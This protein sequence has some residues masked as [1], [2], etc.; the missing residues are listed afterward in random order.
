MDNPKAELQNALKEAMRNKDSQRRDTLRLVTS[1]IKQEEVDSRSELDA[2][3]VMK[4]LQKEAKKRRESIDE[5]QK[6]GRDEQVEAEQFELNVIEEFL[7]KQLS[8][9]ELRPIV[10]DAIDKVGATSMQ[11]MGNIM[12]VVMPKVQGRADGRA[13]N[14]VV[15]ELLG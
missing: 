3:A 6:A 8:Q 12:K 13:V 15:R 11:D 4:I 9:D 14:Q 1:V 10:Q 5:L 7:P 2:D